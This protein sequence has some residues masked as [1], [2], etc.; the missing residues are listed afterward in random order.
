[1]LYCDELIVNK[2]NKQ[3][4]YAVMN[5]LLTSTLGINSIFYRKCKLH[6][7]TSGRRQGGPKGLV[8]TSNTSDLKGNLILRRKSSV[9]EHN[10]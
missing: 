4:C 10:K 7:C 1:M 9:L 6:I 8:F 3:R 5:V 2:H